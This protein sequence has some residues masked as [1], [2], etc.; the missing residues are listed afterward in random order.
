LITPCVYLTGTGQLQN[1]TLINYTGSIDADSCP[2]NVNT[3]M[4]IEQHGHVAVEAINVAGPS[5]SSNQTGYVWPTPM[6][7]I[8]TVSDPLSTVSSPSFSGSCDHT[9]YSITS[10]NP[11]LSP[12][13]Y[14]KGLNISNASVTLNPG[15]YVITGGGTWNQSTI[16]G[17]GVTLYFTSGG[18][19]G[20]GQFIVQNATLN[21][22]AADDSSNSATPAISIFADRSW[23]PTG[24]QDFQFISSSVAGDGIWYLP[25]AGIELWSCGTVTGTHYMGLVADNLFTAGSIYTP[26]NNYSSVT[27]GNPFRKL[28]PLV[29]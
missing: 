15:L 4:Y 7:N 1:Y 12:G 18:G 20:Y 3:S 11:T 6:F 24:S 21:L 8:P 13:N 16:T 25:K 14:C 22:S 19:A 23:T 26:T 10:G 9:S 27:T 2:I 5:G 17:S 28:N 29:Q